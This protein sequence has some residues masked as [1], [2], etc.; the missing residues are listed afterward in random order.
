MIG[1]GTLSEN[2]V[3][4]ADTVYS[5]GAR[6]SITNRP[7]GSA[8]ASHPLAQVRADRSAAGWSGADAASDGPRKVTSAPDTPARVWLSTTMPV[9]RQGAAAAGGS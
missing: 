1:N 5:P 7:S 2:P 4:D 6:P 8:A 3:T 9:T